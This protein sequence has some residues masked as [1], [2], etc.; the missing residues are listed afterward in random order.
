MDQLALARD[1]AMNHLPDDILQVRAPAL[2]FYVL[3]GSDGLYLIDGGFIGGR[4]LLARALR[5]RGWDREPIKGILVTHGHLDH[6]LNVAPIAKAS[7]AWIAAPRLDALHIQGRYAYRGLA[8]ICGA[9]EGIGRPILGYTAFPVDRWLDDL[10]EVPVWHGLTAIHLPGHT[11]GHIGFYCARLRLL[12][13]ADLFASYGAIPHLPPDI[14]NSCPQHI[15]A[16][17]SRALSLDLAG[18]LPNHCDKASPA[19]HLTRLR[20]FRF[21]DTVNAAD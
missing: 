11:D 21:N 1:T 7:G 16:S 9:L 12:F 3:R 20:S 2:C 15:P 13:C 10:S 19:T 8:R 5:K 18:V 6:I 17:V 4:H 14:F